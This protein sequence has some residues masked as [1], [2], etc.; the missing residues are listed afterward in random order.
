MLRHSGKTLIALL[1]VLGSAVVSAPA[2][3]LD[4]TMDFVYSGSTPAG[5]PPWADASFTV[6][7]PTHVLLTLTGSLGTQSISE[8]DFN[9]NPTLDISKLSAKVD[10]CTTCTNPTIGIKTDTFQADGDGLFDIGLG[11]DTSDG[12]PT[13]FNNSDVAKI[14][15]TYSG[16]GTFNDN[17]F[18]FFSTKK[19]GAG[20][21]ESAAHVQQI[22]NT[23]DASKNCS[24]WIADQ[25]GNTSNLSGSCG[26]VPEPASLLLLGSSV[27]GLGLAARR[28][29]RS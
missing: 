26:A 16:A 20:P 8:W 17:S 1:M 18:N 23:S 27:L 29:G 28:F 21:F 11:F 9:F 10:S 3:A 4:F 15:F 24:G 19:G 14:T 2:E 13:R 22:P 5:S 25:S 6:I 12:A 7:D